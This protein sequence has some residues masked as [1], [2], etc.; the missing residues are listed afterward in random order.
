MKNIL[1]KI[2]KMLSAFAGTTPH[3]TAII[4]AAGKSTRMGGEKTKQI[5]DI[6]G[7]PV[8]VRSVLTFQASELVDDIIIVAAEEEIPLYDDYIEKYSLKKVIKVVKGGACRAESAKNGFLAADKKNKFIAIHDA[9]RCFITVKQIDDVLRAAYRHGASIAAVRS[10]DTLKRA[11]KEEF[12][13]KTIDRRTVWRAQTPQVF[14]SKMYEVALAKAGD[15]YVYATDDASLAEAS[16]F[17]VKLV[18]CGENNIKIT[19]PE[20]LLRVALI[21]KDTEVIPK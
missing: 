5:T 16:G 11:D 10:T 4:L 1:N 21:N 2:D 14:L 19:Y 8:V 20:D 17:K 13:S 15:K 6:D 18:E 7:I 3:T 9:A 12:I